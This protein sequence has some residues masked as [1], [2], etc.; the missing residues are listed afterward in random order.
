MGRTL[1]VDLGDELRSFVEDLVASGDY[2]TPSE[3]H[4]RIRAHFARTYRRLKTG[5]A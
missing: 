2:R 3:S 4:P 1:T 5:R